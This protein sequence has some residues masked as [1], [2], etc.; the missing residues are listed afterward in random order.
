VSKKFRAIFLKKRSVGNPVEFERGGN[1]AVEI[2]EC[3]YP[4][5]NGAVN[6]PWFDEV[7]KN[8]LRHL[9]YE[10]ALE[11]RQRLEERLDR[12]FEEVEEALQDLVSEGMSEEAARKQ[13]TSL[14]GIFQKELE[15]A[16][17]INEESLKIILRDMVG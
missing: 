1:G 4:C 14:F 13:L 7:R 5:S 8:T 9:V 12:H 6:M 17:K 10:T 15:E 16:I 11:N 2:P 3:L